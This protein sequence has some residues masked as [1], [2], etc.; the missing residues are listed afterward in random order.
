MVDPFFAAVDVRF[1]DFDLLLVVLRRPL[2]RLRLLLRLLLD[3][4]RLRVRLRLR[5]RLRL[6]S[7][8]RLRRRCLEAGT[9]L[10]RSKA[11]LRCDARPGGLRAAMLR[12]RK[13]GPQYGGPRRGAHLGPGYMLA[14]RAGGRHALRLR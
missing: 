14:D 6:L 1:V 11:A 10:L 3:R 2:L 13:L 5:L 9:D 12:G 7:R 4:L 8:L